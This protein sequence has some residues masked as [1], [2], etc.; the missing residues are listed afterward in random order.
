MTDRDRIEV[1]ALLI[2]RYLESLLAPRAEAAASDAAFGPSASGLDRGVRLASLRLRRDLP[3]FHPSFRF[4][5]RLAL[6]LA[7]AA[8]GLRMAAAAGLEGAP[9]PVGGARVGGPRAPGSSDDAADGDPSL[10]NLGPGLLG[11]GVAAGRSTRPLLIGGAMASAAISIAG[12]AFMA[13]RRS[14]PGGSAMAR[15]VRAAHAA[16]AARGPVD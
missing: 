14:R 7:E 11:E 15:A 2:D 5:E 8:A 4:E 6:Q 9:I 12:A 16:R 10:P 1:E 13:W 3:R